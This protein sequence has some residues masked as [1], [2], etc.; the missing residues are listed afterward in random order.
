MAT[1]IHGPDLSRIDPGLDVCEQCIEEGTDWFTR[2]QCLTCG[3]TLCC[4][5]SSEQH[6]SRHFRATGHPTM[7]PVGLPGQDWIWCYLDEATIRHRADGSW[8]TFDAFFEAGL[9]P[10]A[11]HLAAGGQPDEDPDLMTHDRFPLGRW[12]AHVA[13]RRA[14]AD[15]EPHELAQLDEVFGKRSPAGG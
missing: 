3:R 4:D 8:E 6:M 10:A 13:F 9:E 7:R 1:C 2:R 12:F 15:L 14:E 5:S 11:V